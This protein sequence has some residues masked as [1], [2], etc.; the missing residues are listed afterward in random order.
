MRA[1]YIASLEENIKDQSRIGQLVRWEWMLVL[2]IAG[3]WRSSLAKRGHP[4]VVTAT[5]CGPE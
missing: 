2:D 3:V 5:I 1:T 4:G